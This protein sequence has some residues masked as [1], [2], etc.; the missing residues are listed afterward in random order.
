MSVEDELFGAW[1]VLVREHGFRKS[2][3]IHTLPLGK[4][5]Q[6]WLGLNSAGY[7]GAG[8]VDV[9][10]VM[11]VRW[12]PLEKVFRELNPQL[13]KSVSPALSQPL[14]YEL[15]KG[16][17]TA[18]NGVCGTQQGNLFSWKVSWTMWS[19]GE[20]RLWSPSVILREWSRGCG[21][22]RSS[23]PTRVY[24]GRLTP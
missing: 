23:A 8:P 14:S 13:P 22:P 1:N 24:R 17:I 15:V 12:K 16:R 7:R 10:P 11:G 2:G 18:P 9:L 3:F 19:V 20:S 6:G 5:W 4:D 21:R